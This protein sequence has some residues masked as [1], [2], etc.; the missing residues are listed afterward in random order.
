MSQSRTRPLQRKTLLAILG[1]LLA[2]LALFRLSH[3]NRSDSNLTDA[4]VRS[5]TPERSADAEASVDP[6]TRTTAELVHANNAE[7]LAVKLAEYLQ[8]PNVR[9]HE[10][11][12][13][14]KDAEGYRRFVVRAA[15]AGVIVVRQIDALHALRVRVRAY[16]QFA[17]DLV[18]RA[19]DFGGVSAN[20][21]VDMPPAPATGERA[22]GSSVAVG[23]SLFACLGIAATP[24][25]ASWGRG[26]I[27][28]LLDGGAGPDPTFGSRLRYLDIGLG[29]AGTGAAGQHGTAVASIV[30]GATTDSPGVAPAAALLSIRVI[31]TDDH[32]DVFSVCQGIVAAVDAGA[33]IINLSLGGRLNSEVLSRAVTYATSRGVVLVA[34]AGNDGAN[35]LVWPAADP[36][37]ISVGATDANGRQ[38]SFSNSAAQLRLTAPGVGLAAAGLN[39][40]RTLFSGTSASAPVVAGAL[41]V[42]LSQTP[43]LTAMQAAEILQTHADDGGAAG[44]D[45]QYGHGTLNLG[46][47]LARNDAMRNDTAISSHSFNPETRAIEVVVQNRS[48]HPAPVQTLTIEL[49]GQVSTATLPVIGPGACATVAV[50]IEAS[51]TAVPIEVRTRL[52]PVVGVSDAVPENNTRASLFELHRQEGG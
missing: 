36:R 25:T 20:P 11:V 7:P 45:P 52:E 18:A 21:F 15:K 27:V 33:Q 31:D 48:S 32:G 29:Y 44:L 43:G 19:G 34:A 12:L 3:R 1:G 47:A 24:D 49:N 41:A 26:V 40:T 2:L 51:L 5:Q 35:R 23:Q 13:L 22:P 8:R 17:A 46:W 14:F 10:A 42:I 37:V 39:Q 6:S 9:A 16:D 30:G 38:A 50:P 28:A 4:P